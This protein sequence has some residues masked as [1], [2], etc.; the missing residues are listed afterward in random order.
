M[1]DNVIIPATGSGSATPVVATDDVASVHYQ[2]VKLADGTADS[3]AL[4]GGDATNGLDVDVTRVG[5]TVTVDGS[6]V[7]QPI[8]AA[9]LP[10]PAGAATSANQLA[11]GHNVTV[12][13]GAAG[14]AVNVQDGGNTLTVDGTVTADAGTGPWPVTDNSGSLTVDAPAA[15]PVFTRSSDGTNSETQLYDVDSGAGSEYIQGASLRKAASGASVEYGTATD[16]LRVD[17]TGTTTQPVSGTVTADQGT[18]AAGSGAWPTTITNTSDAVVKPGDSVN[19]A[20]RCNIVAGSSSGTEYADGAARGT[21]TGT[22]A[23]GDDGTLIQSLKCDASGVLAIQ[24]DSGSITV[25][26]ATATNLKAEVIGTGAFAVQ[27]S[28]KLADNAGFTDGTTPVQPSGYIFDEVAG[29]A[30]TENDI[31]SARM[32]SKRAVVGVIEDE[33]IRGR[34]ATVTAANALKTDGSA[35]T[36]PV[37]ATALDI[38]ALVNTDVVTAEQSTAA[39]LNA[40]V[41]QA[42]NVTVV[43][44]AADGGAVSGN[45]VRVAG[46]DSGGLTQDLVTKSTGLL[47][48]VTA[49]TAADAVTNAT[50]GRVGASNNTDKI[51]ETLNYNYNG[52]TW[53]RQRGNT[54]GAFVHGTVAH[55]AITPG[56]PVQAGGVAVSGSA[57]PT[58]VAAADA[59]RWIFNQAGIPYVMA[60]HPNLI[61]REYDFGATAQTDTNLA[62]ALV[63]ADERVYV[64]RFEA[65]LD[66]ASTVDVSVRAGFGA[67]NVPTAS[68][69]GVSG[70]I[71]SHPGLAPNSGLV[72]GNGSGVI[73]VGAAGAEP[74]LTSSAATSGNLH[75]VISYFL[76]DETP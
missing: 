32:D 74:R 33:T 42:G 63:A 61:T 35:V 39:S 22:L 53:D 4:I 8:S 50:A 29:T 11:D 1:A 55:D 5:G 24:D 70:M 15:T 65:T 28:E 54:A 58:S 71:S 76:I 40:T 72:S 3:T 20:I 17:T 19:N 68:S 49:A 27:D 60:G 31:G 44:P 14:A 48:T 16:P 36:Q 13:N 75:V 38:R 56:N 43:G 34:R 51:L 66:G 6:G 7:T 25:D 59:T 26:Q 2:I 37:S 10:L 18:A 67:A 69:S 12:D 46:K 9:A 64:T 41:T 52:T 30:L 73:A 21:A 57:T 23:M 62:A 45:P 47:A